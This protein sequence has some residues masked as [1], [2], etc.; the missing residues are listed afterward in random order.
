MIKKDPE[1][2]ISKFKYL[3]SLGWHSVSGNSTGRYGIAFE[4]LLGKDLHENFELPDYYG[5]E[6]KTRSYTSKTPISLFCAVPDN[7]FFETER[8]SKTYGKVDREFPGMYNFYCPLTTRMK[9]YND[10]YF[11]LVVDHKDQKLRL[12]IYDQK[13]HLIENDVFWSFDCL[14]EK[15][16]RKLDCLALVGYFKFKNDQVD[17][18]KLW[19]VVIYENI[20]F[21]KFVELIERNIIRISCSFGCNRSGYR[22]GK[23]RHSVIFAIREN[24]LSELYEFHKTIH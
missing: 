24:Y 19:R 14:R 7:T 10:Y 5:V 8:I 9:K 15:L 18:F 4:R 3:K 21:E 23:P 16:E 6:I 11:Q 1:K 13:K 22:I 2:I 17:K 20:N 12:Y